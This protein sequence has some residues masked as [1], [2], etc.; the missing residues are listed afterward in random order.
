VDHVREELPSTRLGEPDGIGDLRLEVRLLQHFEDPRH[1]LPRN[2]HVEVL[3]ITP[4]ACVRV[5]R[6]GPA[7]HVAYIRPVEGVENFSVHLA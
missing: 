6:Q 2:E 1:R 4:D 7:E 5:Q 3:G